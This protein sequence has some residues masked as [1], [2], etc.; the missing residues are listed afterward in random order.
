MKNSVTTDY[1]KDVAYNASGQIT[2]TKYGNNVTSNYTY[3]A[4]TLRLN[5]I[6]TKKPDGVTTEWYRVRRGHVEIIFLP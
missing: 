5:N 3:D 4:N 1:L 2:F 6:L